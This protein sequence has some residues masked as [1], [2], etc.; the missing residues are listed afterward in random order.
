MVDLLDFSEQIVKIYMVRHGATE[1]T[2]TGRIC[3]HMD[4]ELTPTGLAQAEEAADWFSSADL[5]AIFT[6]PLKRAMQ[7]TETIAKSMKHPTYFKH[8]GLIEK[9][10]G[11]WDGKTYWEIRDTDPKLWT[12]WSDNPIDF[13]PP[14]GESVRDFVAR[15]G[16]ALDD[17]ITN[18]NKGNKILLVT[19]S[20]VIKAVIMHALNIP[21]ENFFR[22]DIPPASISRVDWSQNYATLKF[23]GLMPASHEAIVI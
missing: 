23:S 9:K 22:I 3:G 14:G 18:H 19:H 7:T 20:G 15:V 8:S 16:R 10:E 17:I 5:E 12:K 13:A 4:L 6:S 11:E 21:V 2:D 1:A